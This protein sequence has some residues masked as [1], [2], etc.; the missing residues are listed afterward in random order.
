MK[1]IAEATVSTVLIT[2]VKSQFNLR[3]YFLKYRDK[4]IQ[5]IKT[6]HYVPSTV[7]YTQQ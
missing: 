5:R 4:T 1:V 6:T 3:K 7:L 2:I